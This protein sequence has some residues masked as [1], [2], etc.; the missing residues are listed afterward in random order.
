[1]I[2]L[3]DQLKKLIYHKSDGDYK[4]DICKVDEAM[5]VWKSNLNEKSF[6]TKT[7]GEGSECEILS[8]NKPLQV[9]ILAKKMFNKKV[10]LIGGLENFV[11]VKDVI[12]TFAKHFACAVTIKDVGDMKDA[13]CIQGYWVSDLV[14]LLQDEIKLDKK[15]IKV[16]DKLNIKKK[17]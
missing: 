10:T 2:K 13:V 12:K 14:N 3:T 1:M 6:I 8:G 11:N 15:F 9:K 16:E 5:D 4:P 17:K 7:G